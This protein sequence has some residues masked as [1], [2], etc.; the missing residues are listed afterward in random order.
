MIDDDLDAPEDFE[1]D[2][3]AEKPSLREIWENN[4]VLKLVAIVLVVAVLLGSYL[5]FPPKTTTE[6]N[7][8][9]GMGGTETKQIPGTKIVD[10]AYRKALEEENKKKVEIAKATGGSAMPLPIA[11]SRSTGLQIPQ[12]PQAPQSDV[13]AEWRRV[14]NEEQMKAAQNKIQAESAPPPPTVPVVKPIRPVQVVKVDKKLAALLA[15][16]MRVILS[17]QQPYASRT[18]NI[19]AVESRYTKM[20][21][22]QK[23]DARKAAAQGQGGGSSSGA[24]GSPSS[25]GTSQAKIIVPAGSVDYA[26]LLTKIDTDVPGPILAQVLSGP[27]SGGRMIGTISKAKDFVV[28]RFNTVVKDT[29]SYSIDAVA[30]D[31]NTTLA[32]MATS[33]NHHYMVKIVLPAAAAFLTGYS[34]ALAQPAQQQTA[35]AGGGVTATQSQSST[36][37]S[38]F[39]GLQV[40]ASTVSGDLTK[41][42]S[43]PTTIIV[44]KGTTMGVFY[45]RTVTTRDAQ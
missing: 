31:Q 36:K 13:L 30:V 45:T 27:F 12:I 19:T 23:E 28:I 33:V 42:A 6:S 18:M 44:A 41:M 24:G 10:P 9:I 38:M 35:T 11:I 21:E 43:E 15:Q 14:A 2:A 4:P 8:V 16:Q 29:V 37:Q 7:A 39:R 20:L 1:Q 3:P 26:Q 34:A 25:G 5:I 40:A 22:Q 17:A 32:G